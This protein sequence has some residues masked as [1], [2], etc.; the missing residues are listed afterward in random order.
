MS[1]TE[2]FTTV[3]HLLYSDQLY[4]S[5][6]YMPAYFAVMSVI[7]YTGATY[8]IF[9]IAKNSEGHFIQRLM[10][11]LQIRKIHLSD[12]PDLIRP[13]WSSHYCTS[14]RMVDNTV[15]RLIRPLSEQTG[16]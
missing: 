1:V 9:D 7:S 15:L 16:Q 14:A 4:P 3:V 12:K 8:Q 13:P 11:A 2:T 10:C 5:A 6:Q